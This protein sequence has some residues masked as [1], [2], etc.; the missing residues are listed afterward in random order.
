LISALIE[1]RRF[2]MT[3]C[4]ALLASR[5]AQSSSA[6]VS[7]FALRDSGSTSRKPNVSFAFALEFPVGTRG[8]TAGYRSVT[9]RHAASQN[10]SALPAEMPPR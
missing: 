3:A 1:A 7:S 2:A 5:T 10:A 6:V 8:F 9:V 4:Q